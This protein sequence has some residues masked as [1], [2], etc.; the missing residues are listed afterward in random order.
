ME[1]GP[2]AFALL[3]VSPFQCRAECSF[4]ALNGSECLVRKTGGYEFRRGAQQAV[5]HPDVMV[6]ERQRFS[7]LHSFEPEAQTAEFGGHRINVHT[8]K[9]AANDITQGTL[10]QQWRRFA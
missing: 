6:Q 5:P 7:R 9:T 3:P 1:H 2:L 4:V 8:I 10:I